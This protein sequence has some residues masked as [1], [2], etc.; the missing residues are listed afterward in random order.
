M[1][2]PL[3]TIAIPAY[4]VDFIK[5]T[6]KSALAQTYRNI[7]V[8]VV[9]DASPYDIKR[10]TDKFGDDAR[11]TYYRNAKNV[12]AQDPSVN[13]NICL[14]Y[15]KGD[16]I[17]ILCDDDLYSPTFVETLV[18]LT[19]RHP[20]CN[21]FR[22]GAKM[23]DAEGN[24]ADLYPLAP[25]KEDVAEYVWHLH[26]GNGRQ[27]MSEWMMRRSALNDIGGYVSCPMAWGSD[28]CTVFRLA[29]ILVHRISLIGD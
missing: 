11:L 27:T 4:K 15:A 7:E 24:I 13:W 3:V 21:V 1:T 16:F 6:I 14:K 5:T 8:I 29:E 26:S 25:E 2:N 10:I 18:E 19:N 9:D 23:I 22:T 28:C 20:D 17:C 12:G